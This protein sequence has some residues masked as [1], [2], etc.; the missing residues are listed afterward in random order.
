MEDEDL[1]G[2]STLAKLGNMKAAKQD[3]GEDSN[4]GEYDESE[5]EE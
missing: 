2:A 4:G 3:A 5:E 1:F